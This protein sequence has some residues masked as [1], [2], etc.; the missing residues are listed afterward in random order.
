MTIVTALP[1]PPALVFVADSRASWEDDA[2]RH[3][4]LRKLYPIFDRAIIGFSGKIHMGYHVISHIQEN[5]RR[6]RRQLSALSIRQDAERWIRHAYKEAYNSLN[7]AE[8]EKRAMR[9][10]FI[11]GTVEPSR[12]MAR[13]SRSSPLFIPQMFT[14]KL[15]PRNSDP[16]ELQVAQRKIIKTIGLDRRIN[17]LIE[18]IFHQH[19]SYRAAV[20]GQVSQELLTEIWMFIEDLTIALKQHRKQNVGG[21]FQCAILSVDGVEWLSYSVLGDLV[22]RYDSD[23]YIQIDK[24]TGEQIPIRSV[25]EWWEEYEGRTPED[26]LIVES[27]IHRK[28][29]EKY[30]VD[31]EE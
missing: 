2:I 5:E 31:E 24:K 20:S 27:P 29:A 22:I 30:Q 16:S 1:F 21:L 7:M 26:S 17:E 10:S 15:V 23:Q 13:G 25:V 18:R 19:S 14:M 6:Y 28:L 11:L 8:E 9:A 4:N 12:D 3:D